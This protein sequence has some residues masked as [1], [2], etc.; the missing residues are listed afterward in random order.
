MKLIVGLGN[1]GDKYK[2]TRH[3]VGFL[4]IDEIG[5]N[6]DLTFKDVPSSSYSTTFINGE[7]VI[8]AKPKLYMNN[9]GKVIKGML[10]YFK[11]NISDLLV[12]HDDKDQ[13]IGKHKIVF[14][15]SH[16][17]QNGIRDIINN[18]NSNEF[19]RLKIGIGHNDKIDTA[20]YVLGK[21]SKD[22]KE[23]LNSNMFKYIQIAKDFVELDFVKLTNKYNGK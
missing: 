13:E 16:G 5:K 4:V 7:K 19:V 18:L 22:Q 8:F 11:I 20:N 2:N 14:K 12:I 9:S 1:N 15:S 21:L 10:D 17:G 23:I 6:I 3:N